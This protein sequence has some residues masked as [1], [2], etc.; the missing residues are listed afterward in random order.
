MEMILKNIG[1]RWVE[2]DISILK[3]KNG[4]YPPKGDNLELFQWWIHSKTGT[5][6]KGGPVA[7]GS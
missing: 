5:K 4:I 6:L 7:H 3:Q 1:H 2:K